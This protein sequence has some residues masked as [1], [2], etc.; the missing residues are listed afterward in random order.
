MLHRYLLAPLAAVLLL[1][2]TPRLALAQTGGVRIGSAGTP[3]A[4]AALDIV[5]TSKGLLLPRLTL[6]QRNA[7]AAPAGGLVVFQTDNT[8]GLYAYDGTAWVRLGADNLGNHTATTNVGLNGYYLSNAPG[9]A[10]GLRVDNA[11]Q[12]GVGT[13]SPA[14]TLDVR[15]TDNTAALTVGKTDGTAGAVLLGNANHGL[16]RNYNGNGNDVG[17]FTTAGTL[18]LSAAGNAST[19]QFALTPG[20]N[21][22]VGVGSPT[23]ALDVQGGIL[24]RSN[25]AISQQGAYLQWNRTGGDGE[26]WLLNQQGGGGG[27]IRFGA[28]TT[29]NATT[30]WA[31]FDGSGNLG[32]GTT[33]PGQKLEVNGNVAIGTAYDLL[34]RDANHGLGWYGSGKTWGSASP[35]GPVLYGFSGGLLGTNQNGTRTTALAWTN[36]GNVGIGTTSPGRKLDVAG[37]AAVSGSLQVG[38]PA[39]D[40]TFEVLGGAYANQAVDQQQLASSGSV[41]GGFW[42]SFTAGASGV[43]RQLDLGL[44][45]PGDTQPVTATLGVYAGAGTGGTLLTSQTV[46]L[47]PQAIGFAGLQAYP[48]STPVTVAAGQVYTYQVQ[49]SGGTYAYLRTTPTN[50]YAGGSYSQNANWDAVFRTYVSTRTGGTNLAVTA[51]GNVGVGTS[52]PS[53]KLEVAGQVY[54][55]TG[56]FRFPDNTVQTTAATAATGTDFIQNQTATSQT[57][58]FRVSGNGTVGGTLTA[59]N[60]VVTTALTGSGADLGTVVGVGIRADGGLNLGQNTTGNSVY[61]GYGAGRVNRNNNNLFV[62][63]GSG[64]SNTFGT[65]NTFSGTASGGFNVTGTQNTF[66]GYNSGSRNTQG[67]NNTFSGYNSGRANSTASSNTFTG[68]ESGNSSSTGGYNTFYGATSGFDNSSGSY[69]SALGYGAGPSDGTLVNTT[70]V[71]AN[72][73]VGRSNSLVL[74]NDANVGIGTSDPTYPLTVRANTFGQTLGFYGN[75]G[76]SDYIFNLSSQGLGLAEDNQPTR[77][78]VESGSGDVGIGTTIPLTRLS[79]QQVTS[80]SNSPGQSLGELGFQGSGRQQPSASIQ[81]LAKDVD[82]TGHLVFKTSPNTLGAVERLRIT[83]DGNVGIG[84]DNPG[85]KLTVIGA[86]CS[87]VGLNC[88]SDGR[89]KREVVPVQGALASVLKLRGV[90]YYWKQ[91]EFPAKHFEGRRQLGFIAQEIEPFY[92]EMVTTDAD[93]YKSVDY[94]RL[95]PVLVEA[96]KEQQAQIEA[97]KVH[98][99]AAEADH[100]SLLTLQAQ[101]ARLL[102][103]APTARIPK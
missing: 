43:L 66:S 19:S 73:R 44:S 10:N 98:A 93:G 17:L 56:G 94:S 77:L 28:A 36:S 61:L 89:Y 97:L 52:S 72:A 96:L 15:T 12:V 35:D 13:G 40:G 31:R 59:A 101:V 38:A 71:G 22:G 26:T 103:E 102:G 64:I 68:A 70:A 60:A 91:A 63:Y 57:G 18:Y 20:G 47:A 99:A 80:Q 6:A 30:E 32:L 88:A 84:T 16:R 27:G 11:G 62:G 14:T 92:P 58:G 87:S 85:Q 65:G 45:S 5:S 67:N 7:I 53:Q 8:P 54:S 55:N 86:I 76:G 23:Q 37:G 83:A 4:S 90:T 33:T 39:T 74:G 49:P 3:D 2:A 21:V 25:S 9:N 48:L 79:I 29:G 1:A 51:L 50:V 42:Q 46:V 95:T 24:A 75:T 34:V 69:N 41:G 78:F 81:A 100:A 82:A